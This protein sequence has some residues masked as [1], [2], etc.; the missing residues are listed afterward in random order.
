MKNRLLIC[1]L[2]LLLVS[3]G[4]AKNNNKENANNPLLYQFNQPVK[5]SLLK[6]EHV[7]SAVDASIAQAKTNLEKIYNIEPANRNFDNTMLE[8]DNIYNDLFNVL[9]AI[10]LM[11]N[12][13]PDDS[14]RNESLDGVSEFEKY[15]TDLGLDENLYNAV[16]EYSQTDE[17]KA[18]TGYKK[19]FL[20]ETVRSF[21]RNGFALSKE[22]RDELK[23]LQN[24]LNDITQEFSRNIAEQNDFLIVEEMDMDGLPED[25]KKARKQEDSE[26]GAGAAYK[27]DLSYP[28]YIPFM[29]YSKSES[30]RKALYTKYNNRAADKNLDLL[31]KMIIQRQKIAGLLGYKTYAEYVVEERMAQTPGNVWDFE[32]NLIAKVK[33]KA[34]VDYQELLEVKRDYLKDNTVDVIN[35]WE[36]GF[37]NNILL[38]DKYS[39]DQEKVKEYFELNNVTGGLFYVAE[40]LF[41]V[42]FEEDKN[43]DVWHPDVK[44]F[45]VKQD[46]K[47]ISR[48]Y[49]DLHP[50]PNK[51][52]HAACFPMTY[53]KKTDNGYQMPTAALECNFPAPTEDKPALITFSDV[54]TYFHEFGHVLHN[55]LSKSEISSFAGTSVARDFVEAPSQIFENW[56]WDYDVLKMFA[57]HYQTGEV[58][59]KEL[60]DKML[61]AKNVGSGIFTSQQIFY[62][63]LDMTY[64]DG[65]YDPNGSESTTDV[66]KRLQ[67]EITLYPYL[68]GTNFQ[69]AFGHL[70]GYAAGY[71]GYLWALVYAQDMFSVFEENGIMDKQTGIRYR[72]MILAKG[73]TEKEIELVKQFLQRD[74]NPDAFFKS[75]GLTEVQ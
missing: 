42:K 63:V 57:K 29:K 55:V 11:G 66:V 50:R 4:F 70:D 19:K 61:A 9:G 45:N 74:P 43:A 51:F 47:V 68:E 53:V 25:Y 58:L 73:G 67:N 16:K 75:L 20:D 48:F 59:P 22:K 71:Y 26:S 5:Y 69:A 38:R 8:Y 12:A 36:S 49:T 15:F 31:K 17:A 18:L 34:K 32:N 14:V 37:Y 52:S 60:F 3:A 24:E 13:H 10:Y 72:D 6:A 30:A 1:F 7:K 23:V 56:V 40:N 64:H 62:G 54:E 33:E 46:G 21:E 41:D 28:S 27:I 39:V 44:M 2:S 35:P 65:K